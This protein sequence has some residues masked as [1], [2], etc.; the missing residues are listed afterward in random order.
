MK[1]MPRNAY[2]EALVGIGGPVLGSLGALVC[3]V[4]GWMTGSMIWFA[5]ASTGFLL[6]LFN[7][8]PISP[9]DGGRIVGVISRWIWVAGYAVAITAFLM[10][11]HPM[12]LL[13]L[14]FGLLG[15]GR[16]IRGPRPD[17]YDVPVERRV[18]MGFAYF[19][20]AAAL[21]VL[22]RIAEQQLEGFPG[23]QG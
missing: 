1:G 19:G 8:L 13:I 3:L 20:L 22:T 7:L 6:N 15:L 18:V 10:T 17:Y 9:L 5:L 16:S 4:L 12:L 2:V 14:V 21:A 11:F 23:L